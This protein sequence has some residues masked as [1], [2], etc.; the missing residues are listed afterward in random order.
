MPSSS[1]DFMSRRPC[2]NTGSIA[3]TPTMAARCERPRAWVLQRNG[4]AR[5]LMIVREP[6]PRPDTHWTPPRVP[7]SMPVSA[8][9]RRR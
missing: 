3:A 4:L 5:D 1:S 2:T 7:H 9:G 6:C 8:A